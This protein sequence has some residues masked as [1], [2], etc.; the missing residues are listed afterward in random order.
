M[1]LPLIRRSASAIVSHTG[2]PIARNLWPYLSSNIADCSSVICRNFSKQRKISDRVYGLGSNSEG[3]LGLGHNRPIHTPEEILEL[4]HQNIQQFFVINNFAFALNSEHEIYIWGQYGTCYKSF[5]TMTTMHP[6]KEKDLFQY[7]SFMWKMWRYEQR[8]AYTTH[9][10]P[11]DEPQLKYYFLDITQL[12]TLCAVKATSLPLHPKGRQ[13]VESVEYLHKNNIIHRD[14]KPD[15][16]L[17]DNNYRYIKLCDFG[18]SKSVDVLSDEY[19]QS[20]VKHAKNVG[21]IQYMAP[22]GQTTEYNHLIDVYSLALIGAEIFEFNTRDIENG[23]A[24]KWSTNGSTDWRLRPECEIMVKYMN[25][26]N[27]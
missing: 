17:I 24:N 1:T 11:Q 19:K 16:V 21:D 27:I 6:V 9:T 10:F 26:M 23:N 13:L 15:N 12:K 20:S 8:R 7:L 14:L 18:L 2:R 5:Y 3:V 4:R 22:E 25:T